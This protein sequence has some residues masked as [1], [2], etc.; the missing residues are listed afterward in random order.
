MDTM[1]LDMKSKIYSVSK[2]HQP[3]PPPLALLTRF[4]LGPAGLLS[5]VEGDL[6]WP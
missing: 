5:D 4:V 2:C 3:F 6:E 1:A